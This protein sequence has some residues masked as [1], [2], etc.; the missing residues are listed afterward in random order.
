MVMTD[1]K[2]LLL[3]VSLILFAIVAIVY[4]IGY[5]FFP[6]FLV[7]LSGGAPVFSGWLRWSGGT[8]IALGVGALMTVRNPK[9]Q[10]IYVTTLAL[11]T[12]LAGLALVYSWI[13]LEEGVN[14]WFTALPAILV[15]LIS[16][17]L[18]WSLSASKDILKSDLK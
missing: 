9:S 7:K 6:D 15:L 11:G 10:G 8:I 3:K 5:L 17:L 12:L 16:A 2:N 4:G 13:T 14:V 18:W 1:K